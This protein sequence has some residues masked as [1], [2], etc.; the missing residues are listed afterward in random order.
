MG[1]IKGTI[2]LSI[3]VLIGILSSVLYSSV[4][5]PL[6]SAIERISPADHI[7]ERD[8]QVYQDRVV[9]MLDSPQWASFADTNSMDPILDKDSN[10]IQIKPS[11]PDQIVVGDIISFSRDGRTIIHRVIEK[12]IDN[13]GVYYITKGDNNPTADPGKVRFSDITRLTVAVVY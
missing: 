1:A 6:G 2:V 8:I 13:L 5:Y 9:I 4:Q 3:G 11:D 12:D 10:A 7:S